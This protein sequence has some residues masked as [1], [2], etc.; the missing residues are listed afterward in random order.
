MN[1]T[2]S[3]VYTFYPFYNGGD[4]FGYNDKVYYKLLR[5]LGG[6]CLVEVVDKSSQE[7]VACGVGGSEGWSWGR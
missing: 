2:S 1:T 4:A 5:I 3:S 7:T 6:V